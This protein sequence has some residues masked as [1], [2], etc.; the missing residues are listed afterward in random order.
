MIWTIP[1]K[2]AISDILFT[3][4]EA[5]SRLRKAATMRRRIIRSVDTET[6]FVASKSHRRPARLP[7]AYIP[8][9]CIFIL[10]CRPD[11]SVHSVSTRVIES[12]PNM[13][14]NRAPPRSRLLPCFAR[15][16]AI[17]KTGG[18]ACRSISQALYVRPR[19]APTLHRVASCAKPIIG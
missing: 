18:K 3:R 9:V 6:R 8:P 5:G 7:L 12:R 15:Y 11:T 2:K 4:F 10:L 19:T 17:S 1:G 13:S 16:V 14:A